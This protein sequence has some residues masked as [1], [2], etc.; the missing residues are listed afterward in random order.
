MGKDWLQSCAFQASKITRLF[1]DRQMR[2]DADRKL[3]EIRWNIDCDE[4]QSS[5]GK[6]IPG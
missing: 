6:I 1:G 3:R 2:D 5:P 4:R